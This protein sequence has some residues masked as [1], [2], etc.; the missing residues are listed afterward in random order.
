[1]QSVTSNGVANAL[2]N[3][4]KTVTLLKSYTSYSTSEVTLTDSIVNYKS[5]IVEV[6][7]NENPPC[8]CI[9][10]YNSKYIQDNL[11]NTTFIQDFAGFN[12]SWGFYVRYQFT[13]NNKFRLQ[14]F[15][16]TWT[17]GSCKVWGIK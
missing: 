13:A 4:G 15:N 16:G 2:G 9:R 1:M 10:E 8:K 7:N 3:L 14:A 5:I 11:I 6:G 12:E 17:F